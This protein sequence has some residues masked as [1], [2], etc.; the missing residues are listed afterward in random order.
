M[1]NIFS[2]I[3]VLLL[4]TGCNLL[5]PPNSSVN[6][7]VVGEETAVE[8][9]ES[10]LKD[11]FSP[12]LN[13]LSVGQL[14]DLDDL[15]SIEHEYGL[16]RDNDVVIDV[17]A[18]EQHSVLTKDNYVLGFETNSE[19]FKA[20]SG[21]GVNDSVNELIHNYDDFKVLKNGD[22]YYIY[23]EQYVLVF[24]SIEGIIHS[25]GLYDF[26]MYPIYIDMPFDELL[27]ESV[28]FEVPIII[29]ESHDEDA[30]EQ[31]IV[32]DNNLE[33]TNEPGSVKE[34][35]FIDEQF[36]E[37]YQI[38][39]E[40]ENGSFDDTMRLTNFSKTVRIGD[41]ESIVTNFYQ[42]IDH[43][44]KYKD[45]SY[46]QHIIEPVSFLTHEG[47]VKLV[48]WGRSG[49]FE[50]WKT[51][52]GIGRT[53]TLK[54][55]E[56]A[57]RNYDYELLYQRGLKLPSYMMI[58]YDT[59]LLVFEFSAGEVSLIFLCSPEM[60]ESLPVINYYFTNDQLEGNAF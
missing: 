8:K 45:G 53:S 51:A 9:I 19:Q 24:Y 42:D 14:V 54:D 38:I 41:E 29:E 39:S 3:V 46:T 32:P 20:K 43:Y 44:T 47:V 23:D 22:T 40:E 17:Y 26:D 21:I 50:H 2:V 31:M 56:E 35:T 27:L 36:K 12:K 10:K 57:Y 18:F 28:V 4:L 49:L 13:N 34:E 55:A 60:I 58:N 5:K 33:K 37:D 52:E 6:E 59:N 30:V 16:G 15:G 11:E 7:S 48:G 1:R 25:Y